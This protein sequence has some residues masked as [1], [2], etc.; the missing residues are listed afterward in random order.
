MERKQVYS[1]CG[2]CTVRCPIQVDV[3]DG[4]AC[5]VQGNPHSLKGA[6]CARGAAAIALTEDP[7]RP[8]GPMIRAGERGEG[9]WRKV[10]W[11]EAFAYVAEKLTAIQD[12]YGKESVLLSD[13]GGPFRDFYRAWL[14]AIGS[15]NY[16]NH[17]AACARN[18]QNA[19]RSVMGMGRKGVAY[20][21]K[22]C[23]H[24]VLQTR[25][26][27][28]AINVAEVNNTL[29]ARENG[30]KLTSIDVRATVTACKAD[31]FFMVRP[32]TDYGFNLAV[33]N[34]L[35]NEKL[36]NA[37]YV[38]KHFADFD[39]LVEFVKPYTAEWA[40]G[41]TGVK[42][43]DIR[44]FCRQLAEA[45]PAV[46]W[47]PG[48]M[49]ARYTTSFY[50]SRTAYLINGLLGSIGAKGGLPIMNKPGD[51][52]KK[53]LKSFMDLFPKPEAKR[54]DGV[55]WMPGRS[56]HDPGPGLVN[57]AY[58][59]IETGEPYPIRAYI[60]Q[61]HDPLMS[62]PDTAHVKKMWE[63]LELIVACTFTW[64]DSAWMADV[65]LPISPAIE[66]DSILATKNGLKPSFIRRARAMEPV[67]DTK[68]IW[69]I[70]AGLAKAMGVK[71]LAY[72]KIEDIWNFQLEGTGVS[73]E[74]FDATGSVDLGDAPLYHD[75][76]QYE[77]KTPTGKLMVICE[78]L[79][80][81]GYPSLP[82]YESPAKPPAGM[83]RITFGRCGVHTQG[84]TVN[85][86]LLGEQVPEN[87]LWIN[88]AQAEAMG[89][90]DGDPVTISGGRH[91]GTLK[92]FVTDFIHPEAVFMLHGFGHTLPCESRAFGK[93]V[94]DNEL[95]PEGI[96]TYDKA[97]GAV[98]MQEHFVQVSKA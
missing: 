78:K 91:K 88:T 35:I 98:A 79:E 81:D 73:I 56:S 16:N 39:K 84:H 52:G 77:F 19:A 93:G 30:C 34:T 21:L 23:K 61:R 42:A 36:Y 37:D 29:A 66:R 50:V 11:E 38:E 53:G 51:F 60:I 90:A 10:S 95:M 15:P 18:V 13:R 54:A 83:N 25:N 69:E 58:E 26:I 40:E 74:D 57:L 64:S 8:Q 65:V 6:L 68:A 96:K 63:K 2:M 72:D 14:K 86:T 67:Y 9:K 41:E 33:I 12:K 1:I 82:P 94:A 24:L 70:Y 17:D 46:L 59:A 47:H 5:F 97:G 71:E 48:W 45:A 80:K 32:G 44:D 31:N 27:F 55:G 76:D 75:M 28:E 4:K 43:E 62:F 87:V 89:I 3:A 85:N 20:D 49:T 7:E 92:A 22:N